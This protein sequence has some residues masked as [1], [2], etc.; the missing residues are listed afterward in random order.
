MVAGSGN[1]HVE[2]TTMTTQPGQPMRLAL[3][4]EKQRLQARN[5]ANTFRLQQQFIRAHG[6]PRGQLTTLVTT[7]VEGGVFLSS[8]D[9]HR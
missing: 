4:G 1:G 9:R 6:A 7:S 8:A 2:G 3:T 5:D